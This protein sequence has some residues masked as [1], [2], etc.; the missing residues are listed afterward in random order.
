M[1]EVF[2]WPE[3]NEYDGS[4]FQLEDIYREYNLDSPLT[5]LGY[6]VGENGIDKKQR[7]QILSSFYSGISDVEKSLKDDWK[8]NWGEP[9]SP[10]R[11]K[12]IVY[13]IHKQIIN[14][15]SLGYSKAVEEWNQDLD[16]LKHMYYDKDS[17]MKLKF[18]FPETDDSSE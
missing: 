17:R 10:V 9:K 5:W 6:H 8:E 7:E 1:S 11:L 15:R 13:H 16:Y 3:L 4:N 2:K 18:K 14:K 12:Q